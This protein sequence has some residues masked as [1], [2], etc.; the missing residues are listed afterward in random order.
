MKR[1]PPPILPTL[2]ATLVAALA[3]STLA[4]APGARA[5]ADPGQ[6]VDAEKAFSAD[7]GAMGVKRSFLKWAAPDA[8]VLEPDP[9][10]A[11]ESYSKQGDDTGGPQLQWWPLWAGVASSGDLGFT[12][13]PYSFD[14]K[15][16][17]HYFTVWA[18]QPDGRWKWIFDGG[19]SSDATDE[20]DWRTPAAYL[21]PAAPAAGS[22]EAAMAEVARE[23]ADLA[24]RAETDVRIAHLRHLSEDAHIQA[25]ANPPAT[26]R[27]EFELELQVW[28]DAMK[29]APLGGR[30]ASGGDLVFTYGDARWSGGRGHYAHVWQKRAAGWK[31]VFAELISVR[32][33]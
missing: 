4:V 32:S 2:A 19:T 8:V 23:E 1:R 18:R 28:P 12:T 3:I 20:P 25:S 17:G 14:G 22:A 24:K 21:P 30:A 13:G 7:A 16:R 15:R 29:L 31:L 27:A 6:V 26:H 11:I 9:V 5:A 10:N 33:E